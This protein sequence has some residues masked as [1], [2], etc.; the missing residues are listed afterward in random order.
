MNEL[1]FTATQPGWSLINP[2]L[3]Q[4]G[5]EWKTEHSEP[6]SKATAKGGGQQ[7][8]Y[9]EKSWGQLWIPDS[10]TAWGCGGGAPCAR[11]GTFSWNLCAFWC[12]LF[13][14]T[15]TCWW[16]LATTDWTIE[17]GKIL[18]CCSTLLMTLLCCGKIR[19]WTE[20]QAQN[21]QTERKSIPASQK[22][23]YSVI[24]E[25]LG[26]RLCCLGVVHV[27]VLHR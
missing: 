18:S 8:Q 25:L 14:G 23:I 1:S 10:G 3:N 12:H 11:A 17:K 9:S 6:W 15:M 13:I 5:C 27:W 24:S 2:I 22:I 26:T 19:L 21:V 7:D 4:V 20:E 16:C